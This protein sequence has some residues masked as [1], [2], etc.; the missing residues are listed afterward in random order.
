MSKQPITE[1]MGIQKDWMK[2]AKG[3]TQVDLPEFVRHLIEDYE[4]D[5]G[6]ICHAIA[7][8]AIAAANAVERSQGGI[9][10]FQ[11]GAVMWEMINGWNAFGEGP[12]RVLC[13]SD[14]LF[15]QYAHKFEKKI[16]MATW[17]WVQNQ[18]KQYLEEH[19]GADPEVE[20]HWKNIVKGK[21]PFGFQIE[22]E[23]TN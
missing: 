4:H 15:P 20:R 1:E 14:L 17:E 6:T 19:L 13:F 21:V 16:S 3:M 11:A 12:K 18:A 2:Q 9:T 22:E 10:G 5:Y 23:N 7:S 8:A